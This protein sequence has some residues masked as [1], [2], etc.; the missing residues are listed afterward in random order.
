MG[1]PGVVGSI[2]GGDGSGRSISDGD[3]IG[4]DRIGDVSVGV[5][6]GVDVGNF[7][8]GVGGPSVS[9]VVSGRSGCR[10]ILTRR[11][12]GREKR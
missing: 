7:S 10:C 1:A 9:S 5:S 2:S 6:V 8:V 11:G 12:K 3:R 4:G